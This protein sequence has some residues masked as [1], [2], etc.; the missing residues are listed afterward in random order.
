MRKESLTG[1]SRGERGEVSPGHFER[2]DVERRHIH[3][4]AVFTPAIGHLT[5][6]IPAAGERAVAALRLIKRVH[7]APIPGLPVGAASVNEHLRSVIPEIGVADP[8]AARAV[9]GRKSGEQL[10]WGDDTGIVGRHARV[11]PHQPTHGGHA[12]HGEVGPPLV[13]LADAIVDLVSTGGTL[14]AN[15]LEVVEEI[16]PIS[17][18]LIVNQAALKLKRRTIQPLLDAFSAAALSRG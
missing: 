8:L 9:G 12:G 14:R 15:N 16:L 11:Q 18:R 6:R 4:A 2:Q 13:G 7:E 17:A 1:W 3:T 5:G 10:R